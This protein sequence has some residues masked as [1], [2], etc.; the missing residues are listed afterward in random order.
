[1]GKKSEEEISKGDQLRMRMA[2]VKGRIP[3]PFISIYEFKFGFG[4]G[5]ESEKE[6]EKVRVRNVWHLRL[7]DERIVKN[8]E[9][10]AKESK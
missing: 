9:T 2:R 8:F 10:I 7:L 5:S 1:M 3:H 4:P 6:K